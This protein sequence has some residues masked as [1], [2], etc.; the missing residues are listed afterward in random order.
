[1]AR[2]SAAIAS[3]VRSEAEERRGEADA[4]DR[5][6]RVAPDRLLEAR[7]RGVELLLAQMAA[8]EA[9][10]ARRTSGETASARV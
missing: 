4:R 8:A 6:A 3:A 5:G 1:M 2:W 7:Q 9:V 10:G